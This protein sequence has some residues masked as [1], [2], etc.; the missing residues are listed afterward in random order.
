MAVMLFPTTTLATGGLIFAFEQ[1]T[2]PGKII[3]LLLFVASV[4]VWTVMA[5][6]F[7]MVR[8][9]QERRRSF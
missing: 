7:T 6:K 8:R 2:A 5:T 4:F 3:L 1:S 9:A